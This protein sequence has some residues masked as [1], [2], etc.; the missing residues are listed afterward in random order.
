VSVLTDVLAG[1]RRGLPT[2]RIAAELGVGRDLVDAALDHWVRL[3]VVTSTDDLLS[4]ASCGTAA[5]AARSAPSA[6]SC[7]GCPF[8]R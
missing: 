1:A 6:P 5:A 7:V 2:G 8:R 4:C 3:G